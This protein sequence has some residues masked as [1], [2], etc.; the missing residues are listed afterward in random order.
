MEP[1]SFLIAALAIAAAIMGIFGVLRI[2][3]RAPNAPAWLNSLV[4]SYILGT[5]LT[6]GFAG[7]LF[8]LGHALAP[9]MSAELAIL[10]TFVVH[11]G[12][13]SI[14]RLLLPVE[15]HQGAQ[16]RASDGAMA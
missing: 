14:M 10:A 15:G 5:G 13:L 2:V 9:F 11:L 6:V 1:V 8:F 16:R 4:V 7:S 3:M 12:L